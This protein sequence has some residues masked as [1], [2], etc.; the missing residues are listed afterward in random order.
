VR[1]VTAVAETLAVY[2]DG[3]NLYHGLH[4]ASVRKH[5]WLDLGALAQSLRPQS[6]LTKVM[7]FTAPVL[8]DPVGLANQQAYLSALVVHNPGVIEVVQGRYQSKTKSCRKCGNSWTVYEEKE[9]DVN[10]AVNLVA[11]AANKLTDAALIIS[12]DSDLAPG[13]RLARQLNP[14]LFIAAAFPP[15]R[16]SNELKTLMP[17]SFHVGMT[18]IRSS[19]LPATVVDAATGRQW[20]RPA[21]WS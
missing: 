3:F 16:V 2:V 11:D 9:T 15:R 20:T 18:K 12:A 13:V 14:N 4:Q 19:Q 6:T 10:I 8:N 1:V 17:S 21:R 5:L 7:Y